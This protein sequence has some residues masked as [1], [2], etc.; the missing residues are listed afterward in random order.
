MLLEEEIYYY[1]TKDIEAYPWMSRQRW[2]QW[3]RGK[4]GQVNWSIFLMSFLN[5]VFATDRP[6]LKMTFIKNVNEIDG[7]GLNSEHD[8]TRG[9][10]IGKSFLKI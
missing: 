2:I 8:M 7:I 5:F 9:D 10:D 1:A 6:K 4:G 3:R